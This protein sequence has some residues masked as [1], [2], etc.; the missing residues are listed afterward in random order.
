MFYDLPWIFDKSSQCFKSGNS[1]QAEVL[2]MWIPQTFYKREWAH[3]LILWFLWFFL[4]FLD[5]SFWRNSWRCKFHKN[6]KQRPINNR[7]GISWFSGLF[8]LS[9]SLDRS[10][11]LVN[12]FIT[13][14]NLIRT[15]LLHIWWLF[16]GISSSKTHLKMEAYLRCR[17]KESFSLHFPF[18]EIE[19]FDTFKVHHS[20]FSPRSTQSF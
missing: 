12:V 19:R 10:L 5:R 16:L 4:F 11:K 9:K 3:L 18:V 15:L 2:S 13:H 17:W 7:R 20:S 14:L 1:Y 8:Q 6:G